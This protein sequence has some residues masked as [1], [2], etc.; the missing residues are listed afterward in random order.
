MT[1]LDI[2]LWI[3]TNR[4]GFAWRGYTVEQIALEVHKAGSAKLCAVVVDEKDSRVILGVCV[5]SMLER[6]LLRIHQILCI[7]PIAMQKLLV[8][9]HSA[10]PEYRLSAA[11]HGVDRVY[12][13]KQLQR[14]SQFFNRSLTLI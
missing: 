9:L 6:D 5:A 3:D 7:E 8:M 11:R 13:V 14:M 1:S 4:K 2:A 10:Y 12:T